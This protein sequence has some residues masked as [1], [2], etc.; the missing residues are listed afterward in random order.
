MR[1]EGRLADVQGRSALSQPD[2]LAQAEHMS[3]DVP[4]ILVGLA[5]LIILAIILGLLSARW[6]VSA[7][8]G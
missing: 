5:A 6:F 3:T 1:P 2:R 4:Y 7:T 8:K